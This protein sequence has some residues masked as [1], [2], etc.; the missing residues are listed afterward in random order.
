[1]GITWRRP[2]YR[3]GLGLAIALTSLTLTGPAT[4]AV[5]HAIVINEVGCRGTD[6][7]ELMN[8][9]E[10]DVDIGGWVL[11]DDALDREPLRSSHRFTF[12]A[13]TTIAADQILTIEKSDVGFEF[14]I[15]CDDETIRLSDPSSLQIDAIT[16][17]LDSEASSS[18]GRLPDGAGGWND[19]TPTPAASN[20]PYEA[21]GELDPEPSWFYNPTELFDIDF[22]V[23][24]ESIAALRS[25]PREY[26]DASIA[27]RRND[28]VYGPLD[29]GIRLKGT[30]S[31]R[32]L[33]G[34]PAFLVKINHSDSGQRLFGLKRL[35]LNN[36]VSDPSMVAESASYFLA[37]ELGVVA[38][39]TSYARVR[40][41]DT[42][43][44]LY[45][46]LE[47]LD[48]VF[49]DRHFATTAHIYEG[50]MAA[51]VHPRRVSYFEVDE[52]SADNRSDLDSLVVATNSEYAQWWSSIN[53]V[54]DMP[55]MVKMWAFEH[56]TLHWD[57]YSPSRKIAE[58]AWIP[59]NYYLH[60]DAAGHFTM[61]PSGMDLA[62]GSRQDADH[63]GTADNGLMF[64]RCAIDSTCSDTYV[65]ALESIR[66]SMNSIDMVG[67]TDSV[68]AVISSAV[69]DDSRKESTLGEHQSDLASKRE[70]MA[71]R[72]A[73][74][75]A[76]LASPEFINPHESAPEETAPP[77]P[78]LPENPHPTPSPPAVPT[79]TAGTSLAKVAFH[80]VRIKQPKRFNFSGRKEIVLVARTAKT[81]KRVRFYSAKAK[82]RRAELI[83]SKD[84][85]QG[86]VARTVATLRHTKNR[87]S[88]TYFCVRTGKH[89]TSAARVR[90]KPGVGYKI[91]QSR[92]PLRTINSKVRCRW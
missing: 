21:D 76:W 80:S 63:F 19:T 55:A 59:N 31:F 91:G 27:I 9:S 86:N 90:Y 62:W 69:E 87:K 67:F 28:Q 60:S 18:Y 36:M 68:A 6:F 70:R 92:K 46:N 37:N 24:P 74:L 51:D 32:S 57:G 11:T 85:G 14:G 8:I 78:P 61:I 41:N 45:L 47:K 23:P 66:D 58:K 38:P 49:A 50:E 13:G 72:P 88:V 48:S 42:A 4:P 83:G 54:T 64:R 20:R 3:I 2:V 30:S 7:I 17:D 75:A 82:N 40:L 5:D 73:Q 35:T 16:L 25:E 26:V 43:Y 10:T 44:G 15:S 81:N 56:Y 77:T 12:T 39:R 89:L 1:M 79:P 53:A 29:V 84:P 65:A 52:G 33:N 22:E 71:A 34:K